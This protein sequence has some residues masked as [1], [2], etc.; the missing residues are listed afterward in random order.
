MS[1]I[2]SL[3]TNLKTDISNLNYETNKYINSV[4]IDYSYCNILQN[5]MTILSYQNNDLY[6]LSCYCFLQNNINSLIDLSI[7]TT[8]NNYIITIPQ[9]I[10]YIQE[11]LKPTI[12]LVGDNPMFITI[13]IGYTEYGATAKSW[14]GENL[15]F[16]VN[17]PIDINTNDIYNISYTATDAKGNTRT[18][19]RIVHVEDTKPLIGL[20][21]DSTIYLEVYSEFIDPSYIILS[22]FNDVSVNVTGIVDISLIGEYTITYDASDNEG[23]TTTL[24][25]NVIVEDTRPPIIITLNG[26]APYPLEI[27][28]EFV[29]PGYL[30]EDN[31]DTSINV[32]VSGFVDISNLGTYKLVYTAEDNQRNKGYA[33]RDVLVQDTTPSIITLIGN[34]PTILEVFN[35]PYIELGATAQ[36]N[37]DI[38]VDIEITGSVDISTIGQY[39]I[40]YTVIDSHNNLARTTRSV[41][42]QDTT[43]PVITM[44]GYNPTILELNSQYV[45]DGA[46]VQDNYDTDLTI[47]ISG[48]VDT[49]KLGKNEITYTS[50][51][52]QGNTTVVTRSVFIMNNILNNININNNE[53]STDN[54]VK[55]MADSSNTQL[56]VSEGLDINNDIEIA[57]NTIPYKYKV[58][59]TDDTVNNTIL[60]IHNINNEIITLSPP[61]I[62]Q[63]YSYANIYVDDTVNR[64]NNLV[65]LYI[66]TQKNY[67]LLL[68]DSNYT[69]EAQAYNPTI[70]ILGD[71]PYNLL[72]YNQYNESDIVDISFIA[73]DYDNTDIT[74]NIISYNNI[75]QHEIGTY[76]VIYIV[77]NSLGYQDIKS[78]I[79]NVVGSN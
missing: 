2:T 57:F 61:D 66:D 49:T 33:T 54:V 65:N 10:F 47:D 78:R 60:F 67:N 15:F 55:I 36:D 59:H 51:D 74:N 70:N 40:V 79:V 39:T 19:N 20:I 7:N 8:F 68:I 64:F 11:Q 5:N 73:L 21:G 26:S 41:I 25:R 50:S 77:E 14:L 52:N 13:N 45:E 48:H 35:D 9:Q 71:N 53:T 6:D 4:L 75:N 12:T 63:D 34:N 28:N 62:T 16:T 29:E 24:Y 27:F 44:L 72:R 56:I 43:P 69:L 76:E 23:N 22:E 32:T 58:T 3:V 38:S 42:V 30:V 37:Y 31:Y 18:V 17:N 46:T 1:D